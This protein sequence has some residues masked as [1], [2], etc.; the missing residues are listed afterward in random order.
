[1]KLRTLISLGSLLLVP[2]VASAQIPAPLAPAA[3]AVQEAV[4]DA[5]S[6]DES[7]W[8]GFSLARTALF[9]YDAASKQGLLFNVEP[10]PQ[11]FAPAGPAYPKAGFGQIPP[12][13]QCAPG[14]EPLAG[15]MAAWIPASDLAPDAGRGAARAVIYQNA[16]LVFESFRGFQQ[17]DPRQA[18]A[19]YPYLDSN[20]TAL[21]R[22]EGRLLE[23]ALDAGSSQ[24]PGLLAAFR[25]LR[26]QRLAGLPEA[27][28]RYE[29]A[30]EA[31]NGL[32]VYAGYIAR[33]KVDPQGA[34]AA[35]VQGLEEIGA[36]EIGP[37]GGRFGATGCAL[38]LCLDKVLGT[39]KQ[40]FEKTDRN[41]LEPL[42]AAAAGQTP[43]ADIAFVGLDALRQEEAAA[44]AK[45]RAEQ[46]SQL[47]AILKADG[48]V[49]VLNLESILAQSGIKWSN[50]YVPNGVL[51]LEGDKEIR[52]HY[53]SLTGPGVLEFASSRPILI[54]TRKSITA[55]FSASQMPYMTLDGKPLALTAGEL[56]TGEL[57]IRGD[58]LTLKVQRARVAFM[59]KVLTVTPLQVGGSPAS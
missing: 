4:R 1:M 8:S 25:S 26:Q 52:T 58:H 57:E 29:W 13:V 31:Q 2:A 46:Q 55:G 27:L 20:G 47:D 39:W 59:P 42:L 14:A 45:I 56:L 37:T 19:E 53:Y 51:R 17:T 15:R 30:A 49:V 38:A 5:P 6:V 9:V 11:G 35:L 33:S 43:P 36:K 16:F 24:L 41:S 10:L 21:A 3:A 44:V 23:R 12:D 32:A 22:A 34:R 50:R 18:G 28:R 40:E 48:L 54:E 7:V